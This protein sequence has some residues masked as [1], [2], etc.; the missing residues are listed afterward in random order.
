MV[1]GFIGMGHKVI[2]W[3]RARMDMEQEDKSLSTMVY[4]SWCCLVLWTTN[5]V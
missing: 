2:A 3:V 4:Y 5:L 1:T